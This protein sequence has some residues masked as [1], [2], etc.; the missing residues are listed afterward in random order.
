M[1]DQGTPEA[2]RALLAEFLH[3]RYGAALCM[4]DADSFPAAPDGLHGWADCGVKEQ[5]LDD[6]SAPA[7]AR[8]LALA[9]TGV[10]VERLPQ[11]CLLGQFDDGGWGVFSHDMSELKSTG[12]TVAA[13]LEPRP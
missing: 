5:W 3:D 11:G 6:A 7:G 2:P 10:A 13:A 4:W 1:T 9:E 8:L 12:P